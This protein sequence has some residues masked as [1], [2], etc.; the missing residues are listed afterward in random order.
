MSLNVEQLTQIEQLIKR[1]TCS[2]QQTTTVPSPSIRCVVAKNDET[3]DSGLVTSTTLDSTA[4]DT[5]RLSQVNNLRP[6]E[7]AHAH[8]RR[9]FAAS[10][11]GQITLTSNLLLNCLTTMLKSSLSEI[12]VEI[13]IFHLNILTPI[14]IYI[15]I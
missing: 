8:K 3:T 9:K 12:L 6:Y 11:F 7:I 5:T 10:H 15:I 14:F 13:G 2:V 1:I 4:I